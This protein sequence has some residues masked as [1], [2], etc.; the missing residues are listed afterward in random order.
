MAGHGQLEGDASVGMSRITEAEF[1]L[2]QALVRHCTGIAIGDTKRE[3]VCARLGK[4]LRHYGY[5]TFRQYHEH[6]RERDPAGIELQALINAITTNK[7]E[8][9]REAHHFEF[10][11]SHLADE[12]RARATGPGEAVHRL[13]VW[14]AGCSSGEEA[15]SI[16]VTLLAALAPVHWDVRIL[17]SDIDTD[18]LAA[19]EAATYPE[20]SVR[21]VPPR[22]RGSCFTRFASHG[23]HLVR[24]APVVRDLVTFRR[25]NLMEETWPIRTQF[26]AIFCRN[27][28][29]YFDKA[30]Q[31]RTVERLVQ[32][33]RPGGLLFLGHSESLLGLQAGLEHVANTVYRNRLRHRPRPASP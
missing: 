25:I 1:K 7:T 23:Q 33:L 18:M 15:Y 8:F 26:D 12:R 27:V 10:L 20:E 13:R 31:Q 5:R 28:T 19:A 14:S 16:A 32:L 4:R 24:V 22:L 29:I 2:F 21:S 6:L 9:F 30:A 3:M 11:R 17:A